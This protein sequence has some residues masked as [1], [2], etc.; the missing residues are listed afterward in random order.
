MNTIATAFDT[1]VVSAADA[2]ST[3]GSLSRHFQV[4]EI[5]DNRD[6]NKNIGRKLKV[7]FYD[8]M[9]IEADPEFGLSPEMIGLIMDGAIRPGTNL[10]EKEELITR[11]PNPEDQMHCLVFVVNETFLASEETITEKFQKIRFIANDKGGIVSSK[12]YA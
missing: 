2:G 9:G 8:T 3:E 1:H 5:E 6:S 4:Y 10:E 7:R 11:E 12:S